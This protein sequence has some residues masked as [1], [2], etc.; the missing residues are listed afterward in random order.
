MYI[1]GDTESDGTNKNYEQVTGD[2]IVIQQ[3]SFF[4]QSTEI[5]KCIQNL[6]KEFFFPKEYISE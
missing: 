6:L 4:I 1:Y 3:D 5:T 2:R